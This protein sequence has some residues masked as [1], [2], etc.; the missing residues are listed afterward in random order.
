MPRKPINYSNSCVYRLIYEDVTRYVGSTTNFTTRKGQHKSCS[1]NIKNTVD[2]YSFIRK[3]GGWSDKWSMVLIEQYP[4]CKS[5]IELRKYERHHYDLLKPDLNMCRPYSSIV[6]QKELHNETEKRRYIDNKDA[7]L[8]YLKQYYIDNRTD[9]IEKVTEYREGKKEE[10]ID[11]N[12]QYYINNKEK[13]DERN[14]QY[15]IDN[16]EEISKK[17]KI[18]YNLNKEKK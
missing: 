10:L 8:D 17:A 13:H 9:I 3:I 1:K 18:R 7:I 2:L 15:R 11:Y 16:K 14:R 4:E 5:S 12:K 6:E